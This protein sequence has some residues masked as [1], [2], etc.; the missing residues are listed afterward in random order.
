MPK[1]LTGQ[2]NEKDILLFNLEMARERTLQMLED[3]RKEF[4]LGPEILAWRPND[5]AHT[6]G[7]LVGHI[8]GSEWNMAN[9]FNNL[10]KKPAIGRE[11][12]WKQFVYGTRPPAKYPDIQEFLDGMAEVRVHVKDVLR[13]ASYA[14]MDTQVAPEPRFA[15]WTVRYVLQMMPMHESLHAGAIRYIHKYLLPKR[16]N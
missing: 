11:E 7:W 1:T 9:R 8:G 15:G 14:V 4:G 6:I 3:V 16:Q 12:M 2:P 5:S 10:V 13:S